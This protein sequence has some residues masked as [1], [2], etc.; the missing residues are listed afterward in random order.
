MSWSGCFQ[1]QSL[2]NFMNFCLFIFR[3]KSCLSEV[4]PSSRHTIH[5]FTIQFFSKY[6][7]ILLIKLNT[8]FKGLWVIN[9]KVT[10][11]CE[12]S[13]HS[14][15]TVGKT[16]T[17]SYHALQILQKWFQQYSQKSQ[18]RYFIGLLKILVYWPTHTYILYSEY[19]SLTPYIK[20]LSMLQLQSTINVI[21]YFDRREERV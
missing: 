13:R 18:E 10:E 2:W 3:G 7:R 5:K 20:K 12:T 4:S 6:I 15:F 16:I 14:Y 17:F 9:A 21:V 11:V 1:K 8:F 19:V